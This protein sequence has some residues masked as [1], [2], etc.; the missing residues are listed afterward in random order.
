VRSPSVFESS[1]ATLVAFVAMAAGAT[2][3]RADDKQVCSDAYAQTQTL[4]KDG[5]LHA[6]REQALL[7]VKDTCAEFVRTD[8]TTWL[9]EIE[10]SQP[11]VVLEV[12]DASG[13]DV[14]DAKIE[15]DGHR[16][17]RR[18]TPRRTRSTPART[19]CGRRRPRASRRRRW[20]CARA[21]RTS[22]RR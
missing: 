15:L 6:A 9:A 4:R 12:R 16:G 2:E 20:S 1:L 14:L 13:N 21:T 10:A 5:K 7:C 17:S 8:C 11:T 3:A 19:P 18:S 22:A